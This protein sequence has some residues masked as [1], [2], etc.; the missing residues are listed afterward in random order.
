MINLLAYLF[1]VPMK[2]NCVALALANAAK[3][4][5][6]AIVWLEEC[7]SFLFPIL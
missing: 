6:E 7:L 1:S 2:C 4:N 3:E 5:E